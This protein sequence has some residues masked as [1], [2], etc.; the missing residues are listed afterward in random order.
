MK[1][2]L[3]VTACIQWLCWHGCDIIRNNTG[4]HTK[5]YVRKSD[6]V[7]KRYYIRYGKKDSGDIIALSPFGRWVEVETKSTDG[8]L[9]DGQKKRKNLVESKGGVYVVARN[10]DALERAKSKIL[11]KPIWQ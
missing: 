10:T 4:A 5:E 11:A 2:S 3:A 6:G 7:K 1:E 9:N 8:V